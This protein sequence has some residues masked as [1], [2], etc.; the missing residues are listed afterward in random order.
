MLR[1]QIGWIPDTSAP[2]GGTYDPWK[3]DILHKDF[4]GKLDIH[5]VFLNPKLHLVSPVLYLVFH[6]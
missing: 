6:M 5:T 2:E 3:V 4:K 1:R